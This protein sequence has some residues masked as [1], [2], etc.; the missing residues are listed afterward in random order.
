MKHTTII[1]TITALGIC[2]LVSEP[3]SNENW[4]SAFIWSKLIAA[5]LFLLAY[6]IHL[7]HENKTRGRLIPI[8]TFTHINIRGSAKRTR[9]GRKG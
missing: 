9:R 3:A 1:G 7:A 6:A 2:L 4:L 8:Y 5:A